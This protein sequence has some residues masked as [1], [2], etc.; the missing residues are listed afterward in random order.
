MIQYPKK[1]LSISYGEVGGKKLRGVAT[2]FVLEDVLGAAG[3][4]R[5]WE[6]WFHV[7]E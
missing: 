4:A 2:K 7:K 5:G 1:L 6:D 3:D